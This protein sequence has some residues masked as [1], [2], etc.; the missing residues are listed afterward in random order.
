VTRIDLKDKNELFNK[1]TLNNFVDLMLYRAEENANNILYTFLKD[2]ED[3][4]G[5]LTFSDV[6][7]FARIIGAKLQTDLKV[8]DRVLL[9]FPAGLEFIKAFL[10][11]LYAGIIAIPLSMPRQR[12]T[13]FSQLRRIANHADASAVISLSQLSKDFS[14]S[15]QFKNIKHINVDEINPEIKNDWKKIEYKKDDLAFLQYTSGSTGF[16]KGVMVSHGNLLHN[17]MLAQ[18]SFGS[19][20]DSIFM[21]WLPH[22]HDMGLIGNILHQIY[23]GSQTIL[24]SPTAFLQK[25]SRW[26][27]AISKYHCTISG[28]PNFAYDLCVKRI[29][30]EQKKVIDLSSWIIAFNGAEKV[31]AESINKFS[32]KFSGCGFSKKNFY[33]TYG[34]AEG[35]LFATGG[36]PLTEPMYL[37]V[38]RKS[39]EKN[40]VI[41]VSPDSRN[42][43]SLVSLGT[44]YA[45]QL[46]ITV[47]T[48]I[49]VTC[50]ENKVGEIWIKGPSVAKGYWKDPKKTKEQFEGFLANGEGPFFKT[51][52]TGFI[53]DRNLYLT[54]RLKDLIIIRGRNI[55][56]EDIEMTA[57]NS[58]S[59]L[60][61]GN[62][63]A[64]SIDIENQEQ[65]VLIQEVERSAI[66]KMDIREVFKN[67]SNEIIGKHE[68][69]TYAIFLIMPHTLLKTT[70]GKIKRQENKKHFLENK[71]NYI[72]S[73][74][75]NDGISHANEK[76][77]LIDVV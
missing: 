6:D 60:R 12:Q 35:T 57:Q 62:G 40:K 21:S 4:A 1:E 22:Y 72:S 28:A 30:E 77:G 5:S 51:G 50:N 15:S 44:A 41:I 42:S 34:L 61:T 48:D 52:D 55:Y 9:F 74:F 47:D 73:W 23:C 70:S 3:I 13:D 46:V 71:I 31:N 8:G 65:L 68:L 43:Q 66:R 69:Q 67:I 7:H 64:F 20:E 16:P 45:D 39:L 33:P 75:F 29:T 38:D 17:Q 32:E 27:N 63:A 14:F 53:K 37:S 24:M 11:C 19:T 25:P 36:I 59:A 58:H 10:G 18:K 76:Q 2:G 49:G 26:L 56:P 54:G